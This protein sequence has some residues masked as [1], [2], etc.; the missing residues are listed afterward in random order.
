MKT[1]NMILDRA[2]SISRIDQRIYG[3]FIE[4]LARAVYGGIYERSP[5]GR[6]RQTLR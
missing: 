2:Y 6:R 4:H 5:V 3:P 1:A